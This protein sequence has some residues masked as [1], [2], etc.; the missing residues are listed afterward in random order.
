MSDPLPA[1]AV[2]PDAV[3]RIANDLER[4]AAHLVPLLKSSYQDTLA[5]LDRAER[6]LATRQERPAIAGMHRLLC[7]VRRLEDGRDVREVVEEGLARLLGD[8]GYQEFGEVGESYDPARHEA[9]GGQTERG[10]GRIFRVHRRGLACHGDVMIRAM[11]EVE[12][13]AGAPPTGGGV[14]DVG[15]LQHG[16]KEGGR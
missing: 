11:V 12:I 4:I 2:T 6:R 15:P 7:T 14:F 16:E 10:E 9:L 13:D 8:L 3:E 5:R 1:P